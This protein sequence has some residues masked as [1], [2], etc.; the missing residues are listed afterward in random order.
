MIDSKQALEE[1]LRADMANHRPTIDRWR[2]WYPLKYPMLAWQRRLRWIEYLRNC[3]TG[4]LWRPYRAW[5]EYRFVMHSLRIGVSIHPNVFGPGLAL[6]HWGNVMVNSKARIGANCRIHPGT[7]IG[8]NGGAAPVL[9]DN[10]YIGPGA[11]IYGG[12]K[13]G[14]NVRVGANAVVNRSFPSDSLLVGVPAYRVDPERASANPWAKPAAQP[15]SSEAASYIESLERLTPS[16]AVP[17][18]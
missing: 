11:K 15:V 16:D 12:I 17:S 3:K 9:G 1:Y 5:A 10:C 4:W 13:L 7:C 2:F 6:A 8:A 18:T 14:D